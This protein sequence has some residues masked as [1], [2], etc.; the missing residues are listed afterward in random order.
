MQNCEEFLGFSPNFTVAARA[1]PASNIGFGN[2]ETEMSHRKTEMTLRAEI[3]G[4]ALLL[5]SR[6]SASASG[7]GSRALHRGSAL[8][9]G[10]RARLSGSALML[11]SWAR[12]LWENKIS[13]G[14]QG[15]TLIN[16]PKT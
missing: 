13:L 12:I 11:D 9:L 3:S 15:V 5:G 4:R 8:G 14:F 7:L 10:S 1:G 2:L 6:L 16:D